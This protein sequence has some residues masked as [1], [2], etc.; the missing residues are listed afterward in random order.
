MV[1]A[2]LILRP[3]ALINLTS[4][5]VELCRLIFSFVSAYSGFDYCRTR[6]RT[7]PCSVTGDRIGGFSVMDVSLLRQLLGSWA[8]FH[9]SPLAF[10][11]AVLLSDFS[12]FCLQMCICMDCKKKKKEIFS[13][14]KLCLFLKKKKRSLQCDSLVN[15]CNFDVLQS[16][17]KK[18]KPKISHPTTQAHLNP[19]VK[20]F[21]T[22]Y[23]G[24]N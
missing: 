17:N 15:Y 20:L 3:S 7:F 11:L 13:F 1:A 16:I 23:F 4:S 19:E 2:L 14:F 6:V 12:F 24:C 8:C 22:V 10:L 21:H 18:V 9:S 5:G